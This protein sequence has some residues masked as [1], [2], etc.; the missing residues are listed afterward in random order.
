MPEKRIFNLPMLRVEQ[1]LWDSLNHSA[2]ADDRS[3]SDYVRRVLWKHEF[4]HARTV[5]QDGDAVSD[6][7][8]L[9]SDAAARGAR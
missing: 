8:A 3:L 7:G 5:G 2:A 6:F 1:S 4:G 9:Q